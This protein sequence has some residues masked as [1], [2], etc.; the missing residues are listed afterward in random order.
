M[1]MKNRKLKKGYL[2]ILPEASTAT[3][4]TLSSSLC[5]ILFHVFEDKVYGFKTR[6]F[7][8]M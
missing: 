4:M 6:G 2:K 5:H 1:G 8:L 3:E 7:Q